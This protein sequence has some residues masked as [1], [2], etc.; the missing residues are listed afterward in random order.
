M[1]GPVWQCAACYGWLPV[2]VARGTHMAA[3]H[4]YYPCG[5]CSKSFLSENGRD[6]HRRYKHGPAAVIAPEPPL[7]RPSR[8][9]HSLRA[10]PP[11]LAAFA[12][13]HDLVCTWCLGKVDLT[14]ALDHPLAPTREH[15]VPRAAGGHNRSDNLLLA[16]RRCNA[17]RG[18]IEALAYRRLLAGEALTAAEMWPHLFGEE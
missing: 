9:R 18:T 13:R 17:R 2:S 10:I 5:I 4:G 1:T 8:L 7:V 12:N 3:E 6:Y 14:V 16:H 11:T 15:L